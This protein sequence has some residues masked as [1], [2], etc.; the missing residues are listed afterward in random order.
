VKR[1][2]Q[3]WN[4]DGAGMRGNLKAVVRAILLDPEARAPRNPVYSRFGTFK[5]PV[6][7][8]TNFLRAVGATSD[9]VYLIN[10]RVTNMGE[11]PFNS[12]TV[13]NFYPADYVI[14]GT[15]LSGPQFGILDA[16]TYFARVNFLYNI[17]SFGAA[18]GCTPAPSTNTNLGTCGA[19]N[20]V[21]GSTGTKID[22]SIAAGMYNNPAALVDFVS[23]IL[24]YEPLPAAWRTQIINAVSAV[25]LSATPTNTQKYDRAR[26]AYYLI[27][28]SPKYQ[29]EH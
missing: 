9:G 26:T 27:A 18:N 11:D 5:E 12:P 13:F 21:L 8:V 28:I 6:L 17:L 20:S 25:P 3:V 16:T 7:L 19:D 1:I 2:T 22:L 10:G 15:S 24:L 29:T 14:P 4:N 23:N